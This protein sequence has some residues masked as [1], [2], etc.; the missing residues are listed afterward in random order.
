MTERSTTGLVLASAS[1]VRAR[2]LRAAGVDFIVQPAALDEDILKNRL[3]DEQASVAVIA[4]ALAVA[5]AQVVSMQQSQALVLGSDQILTFDGR[6]V[7]KC[8]DMQ[9]ARDLLWS[10][11]G[12]THQLISALALLRGGKVIWQGRAEATLHMRAFSETFLQ[13]YL[14]AEGPDLLKGV[15]C[16]RLEGRGVHLFEKIEGDYFTVLGLPLLPLLA[17]L[18]AEGIMPL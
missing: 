6:L 17:V 9:A 3:L 7:S 8:G 5:K 4:E 13:D 1:E 18:R 12:R 11:R 10:L 16:Y 14:Q 2:L 15:G